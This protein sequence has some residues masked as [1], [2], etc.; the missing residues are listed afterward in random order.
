M[1]LFD[2]YDS[3]R[4]IRVSGFSETDVSSTETA[5]DTK[6][7]TMSE[8]VSPTTF[9][10]SENITTTEDETKLS[11]EELRKKA[12]N[13]AFATSNMGYGK[14]KK[15]LILKF[16]EIAWPE[17]VELGWN[18]VGQIFLLKAGRC[19]ELG[20]DIIFAL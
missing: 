8:A 6:K 20:N 5:I 1:R 11:T 15:K 18:K 3:N 13:Y 2:S 12:N 16:W 19:V 7:L 9:H 17:L 4:F 14:K 10:E